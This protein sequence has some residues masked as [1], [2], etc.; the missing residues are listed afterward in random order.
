MESEC[1]RKHIVAA[2]CASRLNFVT[3]SVSLLHDGHL[4]R[5]DGGP[6]RHHRRACMPATSFINYTICSNMV[7]EVVRLSTFSAVG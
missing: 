1:P 5:P 6:D 3:M 7:I 2:H 4:D